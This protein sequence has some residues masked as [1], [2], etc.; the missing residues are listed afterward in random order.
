MI[1]LNFHHR[2]FGPINKLI[3]AYPEGV[4]QFSLQLLRNSSQPG[5]SLKPVW[6]QAEQFN[7]VSSMEV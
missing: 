6:F 4:S 7:E 3:Q 5:F 1:S 2:P